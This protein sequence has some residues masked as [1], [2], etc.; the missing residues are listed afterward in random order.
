MSPPDPAGL[1]NTLTLGHAW[2]ALLMAASAGCL[3]AG[4]QLLE[5]ELRL[6][7]PEWLRAHRWALGAIAFFVIALIAF[8]LLGE[9][10]TWRDGL[11][12]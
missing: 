7:T 10:P 4:V 5:G 12:P 2:A 6:A 9:T 8:A 3:W 1:T 11:N